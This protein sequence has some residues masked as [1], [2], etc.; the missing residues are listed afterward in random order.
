MEGVEK[1]KVIFHKFY[2]ELIKALPISDLLPE[3]VANNL[4]SGGQKA[5]VESRNTRKEKTEYFLDEAINRGLDVGCV[6]PFD[7]MIAVMENCDDFITRSLARKIKDESCKLSSV[8]KNED[9]RGKSI[10]TYVYERV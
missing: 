4:L 2:A 8:A 10:C 7:T 3:F 9:T 5:V 6:E 1:T